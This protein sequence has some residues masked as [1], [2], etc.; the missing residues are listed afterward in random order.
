M[1]HNIDRHHQTHDTLAMAF[2]GILFPV[3]KVN[4]TSLGILYMSEDQISLTC[5]D[6]HRHTLPVLGPHIWITLSTTNQGQIMT[7]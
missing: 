4:Y 2:C 7:E 5:F 1:S 6:V 3:M